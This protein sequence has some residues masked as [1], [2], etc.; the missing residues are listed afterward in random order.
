MILKM[1]L[2][3]NIGQTEKK[4]SEPGAVQLVNGSDS[5]CQEHLSQTLIHCKFL[6]LMMEFIKNT[7][8]FEDQH[9]KANENNTLSLI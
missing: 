2:P 5:A 1:P 4:L 6:K 9:Q 7:I 8:L 3:L